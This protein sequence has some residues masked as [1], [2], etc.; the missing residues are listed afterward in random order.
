MVELF[1]QDLLL[2]YNN[3]EIQI[4]AKYYDIPIISKQDMYWQIA[5][6]NSKK[7]AEM[8]RTL[9]PPVLES[10]A[11]NLGVKDIISFISTNPNAKKYLNLMLANANANILDLHSALKD[12]KIHIAEGLLKNPRV[13]ESIIPLISFDAL[14]I[15]NEELI[16]LLQYYKPI[17]IEN[18]SEL[19]SVIKFLIDMIKNN[20]DIDSQILIIAKMFELLD[21]NHEFLKNDQKFC[22]I[23]VEKLIEF[24]KT[25]KVAS[26]LSPYSHL[27]NI[28]KK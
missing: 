25:P 15:K 3:D 5:E 22:K 7:Y 9:Q 21:K 16:N 18:K 24:E 19:L 4:L 17:Y 10:V 11:K 28:C 6:K 14:Y 8:T 2:N 23:L 1:Y 13:I 20:N 12:N 27:K 26:A